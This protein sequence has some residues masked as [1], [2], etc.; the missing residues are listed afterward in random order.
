MPRPVTLDWVRLPASMVLR[1][2]RRTMKTSRNRR[3]PPSSCPPPAQPARG[4]YVQQ[5][6]AHAKRPPSPADR[7]SP[8]PARRRLDRGA[9]REETDM[10]RTGIRDRSVAISPTAPTTPRLRLESTGTRRSLLDGG[11]WPR[12]SDPVA[13]LPGLILAIDARRGPVT[14]DRK[15]VV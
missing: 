9:G 4:C 1:L 3:H 7:P 10:T 13:E 11:W 2:N 6:P 5:P 8:K 14:R 12:S 15:S